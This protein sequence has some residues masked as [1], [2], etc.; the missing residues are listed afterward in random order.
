MKIKIGTCESC[1]K[2]LFYKEDYYL[3]WH[4]ISNEDRRFCSIECLKEWI[5]LQDKGIIDKKS[6]YPDSKINPNI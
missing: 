4:P 5:E 2:D 3:L 6:P 1:K